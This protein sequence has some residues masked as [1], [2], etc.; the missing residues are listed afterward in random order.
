[1][2]LLTAE[3]RCRTSEDQERSTV[4]SLKR[5][6][7]SS[8]IEVPIH[9]GPLAENVGYLLRRAQ[10]TIFQRFFELFAEADIRPVQYSILT[11]IESN[12]GLSQKQLAARLG[13]KKTNLVGLIDE[14]EARGLARRKPTENDRRSHALY[15]T[16]RGTVLI[17]R[18]HRLDASLNA[19]ISRM[20]S[21]EE[22]RRF[23][24][25]L[26]QIAAL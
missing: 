21:A 11:V 8:A 26:R 1:M 4:P 12:P 18:L 17:A 23:C 24:E 19:R 22:R 7:K 15:L 14:L 6:E 20:M 16:P 9:L 5:A 2:V 13:I 10:V 3:I 25:I